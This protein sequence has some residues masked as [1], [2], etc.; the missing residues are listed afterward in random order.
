MATSS[1]A[2][3]YPDP[4]AVDAAA[5]HR[6]LLQQVA[7]DRDL[8]AY[9][10]LFA[11]FGPRVKA[12]MLK[13]GADA[14]VA[15]DIAQ[16]VMLTVWRKVELYSAE[17]G[18][19]ATWVFT[20]ARNARIDRLRHSSSRP[21]EDV[22]ELELASGEADAEAEA[23]AGQQAERVAAALAELPDEQRAIVELAYIDDLPQSR[24]AEK[25]SLPLGTVKSRLRLA[26]G[27][28]RVNLEDLK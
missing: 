13:S 7:A 5:E 11:H 24:I 17:R 26:Y 9:E 12:M 25:L 3:A 1:L 18:S 6:T 16:E 27:K 15:D 10:Q 19:V 28:L 4:P 14:A 20:I 22:A 8:A 2:M 21:Y 23:I